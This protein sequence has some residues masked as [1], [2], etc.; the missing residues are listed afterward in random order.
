VRGSVAT[1]GIT[2][3]S[4]FQ[5]LSGSD[6]DRFVGDEGVWQ[7]SN[8]DSAARKINIE[9]DGATGGLTVQ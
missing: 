8:Y 4:N 3:P 2:V 7:T 9:F 6:E 1:G 5:R